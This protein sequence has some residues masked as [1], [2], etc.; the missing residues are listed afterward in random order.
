MTAAFTDWARMPADTLRR[1]NRS[2]PNLVAIR[3]D[4]RTRFPGVVSVGIYGVR[5]QR[6]AA[7]T[8]SVHS[9][10]SAMNLSYRGPGRAMADA[11][12]AF[13]LEH[14]QALGVQAIHDY[15]RGRIW[16]VFRPA[17]AGGPGWKQQPSNPR[18]GM[19]QPWADWIH[20]EVNE[21]SWADGRSVAERI[22]AAPP[23]NPVRPVIGMGSTGPAVLV[24]QQIMLERAGQDVGPLD[25][26]FGMRTLAAWQNVAAF[27][28]WPV[29][30]DI[31]HDDWALLAWLDQ[32]WHR[33]QAA[34][35]PA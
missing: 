29:D 34:G 3:N 5:D 25:G 26:R 4:F 27:C 17:S 22:G 28:R 15:M 12:I 30:G 2:S 8:P 20:I 16:R 31:G 7:G 1:Y 6:G 10:G 13:L 9:W 14:H 19:G 21:G 18:N 11:A 32:G 33:L 23:A 35:I 24:A